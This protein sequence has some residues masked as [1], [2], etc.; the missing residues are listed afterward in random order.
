MGRKGGGDAALQLAR[1]LSRVGMS[2]EY[3]SVALEEGAVERASYDDTVAA[4]ALEPEPSPIG[5]GPADGS[6]GLDVL[7]ELYGV[8]VP[9]ASSMSMP[10]T[11]ASVDVKPMPDARRTTAYEAACDSSE[12]VVAAEQPGLA[13]GEEGSEEAA[14]APATPLDFTTAYE[15][16]VRMF[17]N[18]KDAPISCGGDAMFDDATVGDCG[19]VKSVVQKLYRDRPGDI[20]RSPERPDLRLSQEEAQGHLMGNLVIGELLANE[21]RRTGKAVDNILSKEAKDAAAAKEAAKGPR[22][23]ARALPDEAA[24]EEALKAIDDDL[25]AQLARR[26]RA[27]PTISLQLP[28]RRTVVVELKPKVIK[29]EAAEAK[30]VNKLARLRADAAR[31]EAAVL[32]AEAAAVA[33]KRRLERAEQ[34][35]A[36]LHSLRFNQALSGWK[37]PLPAKGDEHDEPYQ[38][39]LEEQQELDAQ[40]E[41]L[42]PRVASLR[43]EWLAAQ[44]ASEDARSAAEDARD[45]VALEECTRADARRRAERDAEWAALREEYERERAESEVRM[46]ESRARVDASMTALAR[47]KRA[48][49]PSDMPTVAAPKVFKLTGMSAAEVG[50]IASQVSQESIGPLYWDDSAWDGYNRAVQREYGSD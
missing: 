20:C 8:M 13:L 4:E 22:K 29:P 42:Q 40:L 47:L 25:A 31:T 34:A 2:G 24:R 23:R 37:V 17:T 33:A 7:M 48:R 32:P 35:L 11:N 44:D 9:P 43:R 14:E 50:S 5:D 15:F 38:A 26:L 16:A 39:H 27:T 18:G 45:A 49:S 12:V 28:A 3:S 6:V 36:D 21:A 30:A 46:A 10:I 1:K 19:T 41:V